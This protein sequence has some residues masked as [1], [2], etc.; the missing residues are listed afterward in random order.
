MI[1]FLYISI[2]LH[3]LVAA[4][5]FGVFAAGFLITVKAKKK[6]GKVSEEWKFFIWGLL[7]LFFSEIIDIFT[8]IF[9]APLGGPNVFSEAIEVVGLSLIFLSIYRFIAN[10]KKR[11][12]VVAG[13]R[14]ERHSQI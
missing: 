10:I 14:D 11:N 4:L 7:I 2:V 1:N 12:E 8:P 5:I 3:F 13:D 9:Q 6:Y